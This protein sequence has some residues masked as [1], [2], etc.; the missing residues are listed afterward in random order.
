MTD[1]E[2]L[3]KIRR[4]I[5]RTNRRIAL[6]IDSLPI[7]SKISW[8]ECYSLNSEGYKAIKRGLAE[9]ESIND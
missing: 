3:E 4:I 5:R 8:D 7:N 9:K 1:A 2:K 6:Y